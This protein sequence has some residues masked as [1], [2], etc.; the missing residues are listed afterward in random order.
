VLAALQ[1]VLLATFMATEPAS[2]RGIKPGVAATIVTTLVLSASIPHLLAWT[3]PATA[4]ELA[5]GV[6]CG[7]IIGGWLGC[8][9]ALRR[10]G[11]RMR[12]TGAILGDR[13][14]DA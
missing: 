2:G 8:R 14:A 11:R 6:L 3:N 12:I 7:A 10:V 5:A 4:Q 13:K 1:L 9:A